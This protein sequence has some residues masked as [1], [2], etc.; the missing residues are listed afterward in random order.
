MTSGELIVVHAAATPYRDRSHFDGQN[1]LENGSEKPYGLDTGWLN[2]A[3]AQI[4]AARASRWASRSTPT[5][6]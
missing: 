3:L 6:P 1:L 5:C 2:R 4:A